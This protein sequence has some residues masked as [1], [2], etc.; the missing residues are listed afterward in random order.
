[1]NTR[2]DALDA[3]QDS[4]PAQVPL[5]GSS[6][7][8]APGRQRRR[9]R[10]AS[11]SHDTLG[12]GHIR[13]SLLIAQAVSQSCLGATTLMIAG[14][15]E[16]GAFPWAAGVDCLT[17]PSIQKG[18][19]GRYRSRRLHLS[20]PDLVTV[21]ARIIQSA[22]EAFA[23]D[24]LIVDTEPRGAF[25]ELEPALSSLRMQGQTHCVLGLRD[26]RDEPSVVRREWLKA[27]SDAAIRDYYDQVWV[28]GDRSV[29]DVVK[30]YDL[31]AEVASKLRYTGF[32]DQTARL[33]FVHPGD[34]GP[35]LL[36]TLPQERLILCTVG[37]GQDGAR[38]ARAFV[39]AEMPAGT[40]G[41][42][43]VGPQMAADLL[44]ELRELSARSGRVRVLRFLPEPAPL[45][46][47]AD[48][49]VT[50][51]GYNS[52]LEA[53]SFGKP[54]LIVPRVKPR[55]EQWI[56]ADRFRALGLVDL[57]HPDDLSP[58][59][60]GKWLASDYAPRPARD[61][62]DMN[63]LTRLVEFLSER[64]SSALGASVS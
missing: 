26:V 32:L 43:L 4:Y 58:E 49:L 53:I 27:S 16:A 61:V 20:M 23:P 9:L 48:R 6:I 42:V 39:A 33:E 13:R 64:E 57:L 35:R 22:L 59:R 44:D 45:L 8:E 62:V 2:S 29:F 3:R 56:R 38:L 30:E 7:V 31:S 52:T 51:G 24:V 41:L 21:R 25:R 63:G 36:A 19:D 34:D 37:G 50:M 10:I 40:F 60:L 54:T 5:A 11:Y 47:R 15:R 28:Y 55:L 14:A 17:L 12:L 18:D 46:A 1:M